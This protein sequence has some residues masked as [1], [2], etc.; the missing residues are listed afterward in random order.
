MAAWCC[1]AARGGG[2]DLEGE[3]CIV[4]VHG[5]G[6]GGAKRYDKVGW[7]GLVRRVGGSKHPGKSANSNHGNFIIITKY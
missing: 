7:V 6:D 2:G 1:M 4:I 3:G 5:E